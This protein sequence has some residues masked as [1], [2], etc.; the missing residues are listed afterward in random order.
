MNIL[1]IHLWLSISAIF[2]HFL[3]I[4]FKQYLITILHFLCLV[5]AQ[6]L[7]FFLN[8]RRMQDTRNSSLKAAVNRTYPTGRSLN[9][10]FFLKTL[11][12]SGLWSF[13][14]FPL[15]Q[16]VYTHQAGRTPALQQNKQSSE[17]HKVLRK[18]HNI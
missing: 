1:F 6:T 11:K 3:R 10:V 15:C 4:F 7:Q 13:S 18:K 5:S 17:N 14:V 9:I 2:V 12:Y 8:S 16:C